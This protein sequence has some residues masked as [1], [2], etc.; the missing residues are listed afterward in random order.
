MKEISFANH[1]WYEITFRENEKG[2][3]NDEE[4]STLI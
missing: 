3:Q 2:G 1:R 4:L